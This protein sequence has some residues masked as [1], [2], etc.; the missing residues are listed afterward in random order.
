M[1]SALSPKDLGA[2]IGVSESSLKRWADSGLLRVARTAGGH[3]RIQLQEAI[4]FV[5]DQGFRIE[6]PDILGLEIEATE[7]SATAHGDPATAFHSAL[8]AGDAARARALALN[9]YLEGMPLAALVDDYLAPAMRSIGDY[10]RHTEE[11]I[12]TEH[13]AADIC[14][15][16]LGRIRGLVSGDEERP[17]AVGGAPV[18]E[19]YV[20][21]SLMAASVLASEG[22]HDINLSAHTPSGVLAQAAA[23]ADARLVWLALSSERNISAIRR[24]LEDLKDALAQRDVEA[25]IVVGGPALTGHSALNCDGVYHARSMNELTAFAHGVRRSTARPGGHRAHRNPHA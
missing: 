24:L 2:A 22:W 21:P 25:A 7:T 3:R 23:E 8:C 15:Q 12:L 6:R 20:L 19:P 11:G 1:K 13:R 17:A 4:R 10:W 16:I 9:A 14:N 18:D 5:R